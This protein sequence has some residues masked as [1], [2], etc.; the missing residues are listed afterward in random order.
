MKRRRT[1]GD[2][3]TGMAV[4]KS[5]APKAPTSARLQLP[6]TRGTTATRTTLATRV[7]PPG[8]LTVEHPG[9]QGRGALKKGS[10]RGRGL[11]DP[12]V[13]LPCKSPGASGPKPCPSQP[14]NLRTTPAPVHGTS[15]TGQ[16][17]RRQ[18]SS[19]GSRSAEGGPVRQAAAA[20]SR[21]S[22]RMAEGL[23]DKAR[24]NPEPWSSG[25]QERLAGWIL[26]QGAKEPGDAT[27]YSPRSR[28]LGGARVAVLVN[29]R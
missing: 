25:K 19:S 23:S 24:R 16:T 27:P 8:S 28:G 12:P 5:A 9:T 4:H 15:K 13:D 10:S 29:R 2:L 21:P 17:D 6:S 3:A 18:K 22:R 11:P 26:S 7:R 20:G 14:P 1:R